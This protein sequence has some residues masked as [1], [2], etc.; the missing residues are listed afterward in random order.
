M[1]KAKKAIPDKTRSLVSMNDEVRE[2]VKEMARKEDR[3]VNNLIVHIL[4]LHL[5]QIGK[6]KP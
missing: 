2:I 1:T 6:L 3:S 4:R 5:V